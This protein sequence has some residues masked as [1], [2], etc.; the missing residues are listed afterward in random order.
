MHTLL[1]T[2]NLGHISYTTQI[3][4]WKESVGWVMWFP[5]HDAIMNFLVRAVAR[6]YISTQLRWTGDCLGKILKKLRE[7]HVPAPHSASKFVHEITGDSAIRIQIIIE[8]AMTG[9]SHTG[10]GELV[11]HLTRLS[12]RT[13]VNWRRYLSWQR[14]Y[15]LGAVVILQTP[16][17]SFVT[18]VYPSACRNW[19]TRLPL[20]G[21]SPDLIFDYF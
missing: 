11:Q 17:T 19:T 20:D 16:T 12:A 6:R 18:S 5:F 13:S 14:A 3:S 10:S 7:N 8:K 9:P 4:L 21:F 1:N 15:C 2:C